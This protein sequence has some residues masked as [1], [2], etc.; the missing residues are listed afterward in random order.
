MKPS[1][2]A[3][4]VAFL[5]GCIA[6][7]IGGGLLQRHAMRR[8]AHGPDTQRLVDRLSRQLSLD[9]TQK[10]AVKA[11][12]EKRRGQMDALHRD[13]FAKMEQIRKGFLDELEPLLR[14]DQ[15]E[16]LDKLKA[17]WAERRRKLGLQPPPPPPTPPE[18]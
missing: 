17:R 5:I 6:G 15:K 12:L 3:V 9:D 8:W 14:P 4:V 7:V 18:P 10:V 11:A 2:Q 13:T 1:R 16:K